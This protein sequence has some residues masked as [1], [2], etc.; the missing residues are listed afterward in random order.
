M[1]V[2]I[3]SRVRLLYMADRRGDESLH[4][5]EGRAGRMKYPTATR[6]MD[7]TGSDATRDRMQRE[8]ILYPWCASVSALAAPPPPGRSSRLIR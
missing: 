3:V 5:K 7:A 2:S 4:A 1:R 8:G 6:A